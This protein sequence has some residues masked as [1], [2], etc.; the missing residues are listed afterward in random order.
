MTPGL[1]RRLR[2]AEDAATAVPGSTRDAAEERRREA[3]AEVPA[4]TLRRMID[5]A[6]MDPGQGVAALTTDPELMAVME[7]VM[8]A[9]SP[10]SGA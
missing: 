5:L 1:E 7:R 4:A 3:L 8:A 2:L 10:N 6:D 9:A